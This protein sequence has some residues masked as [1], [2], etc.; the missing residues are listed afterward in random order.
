MNDNVS[1]ASSPHQDVYEGVY[2]EKVFG[3]ITIVCLCMLNVV[4]MMF[5]S[6]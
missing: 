2:E 1:K 6:I 5:M 3:V 4:V